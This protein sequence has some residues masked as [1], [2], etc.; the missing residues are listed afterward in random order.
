MN[1]KF[2]AAKERKKHKRFQGLVELDPPNLRDEDEKI[3]VQDLA[4]G[5]WER[6]MRPEGRSQRAEASGESK[7]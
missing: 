6:R 3:W 7:I 5:V 2:L 4:S 1:T